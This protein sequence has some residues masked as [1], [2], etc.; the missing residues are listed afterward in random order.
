MLPFGQHDGEGTGFRP[1]FW[2]LRESQAAD[3]LADAPEPAPC[4]LPC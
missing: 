3:P 4:R 2:P 1:R